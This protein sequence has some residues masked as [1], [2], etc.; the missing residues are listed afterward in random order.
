MGVTEQGLAA[1]VA[2]RGNPDTHVIL[3]GGRGGPNYDAAS[4]QRTLA[5]LRPGPAAARDDRHQPRQQRQGLPPPTRCGP[6]PSPSRWRRETGI[7]GMMLES[8]LVDG[9]QDFTD[10]AR[11]TPARAS[12]TPAW[13]GT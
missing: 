13:A 4:V 9:R 8:F 12:P 10:R 6:P 7:I 5:V 1:I 3:R 2:T 11:L